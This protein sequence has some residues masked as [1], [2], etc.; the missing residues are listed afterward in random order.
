M[1]TMFDIVVYHPSRPDAER[2]VAAALDEVARL[3]AVM[4]NFKADS[5]LS[6]LARDGRAGFVQVDA[7]LF[8]VIE[9]S[10]DVSRRSHGAF[11]I[12]VGPLVSVWRLA[13]EENRIPSDAEIAAAR[14]CVG[15]E[16]IE[17]RSP[18]RV[19]LRSD[20]I[21]LDLGAIG[22]G[23]AVDRAIA[24]LAAAGIQHAVVNA[25][26]SSIAA[27][28]N[29]PG[30]TAWPVRIGATVVGSESRLLL[31]NESIS[32]SQ[33][34]GEIFD[35]R[36]G[37]PASTTTAVSVVAPSAMIS[38]ALDTTLVLLSID[39]GKRLLSDYAKVSAFWI[40]ANG[41]LKAEYHSTDSTT[42][43]PR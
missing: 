22:K 35:P 31:R 2:A 30:S 16:R 41:E 33:Q 17:L 1:G 6:K 10:I 40:S 36:I 39:E 23:Y 9:T 14:R 15:Y 38:D 4:S 21:E 3:D 5:D 18:D 37:M 13:R 11:D 43:G 8:N 24:V 27:I 7:N 25:G 26:S 32:T 28:G 20:C 34:Q 19:H 12:T 29:P 42:A